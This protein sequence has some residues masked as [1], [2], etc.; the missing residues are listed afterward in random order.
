MGEWGGVRVRGTWA[1]MDGWGL[2]RHTVNSGQA[3]RTAVLLKADIILLRP[4]LFQIHFSRDSNYHT[5]NSCVSNL[6]RIYV[7]LCQG[8][9]PGPKRRRRRRK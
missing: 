6:P 9:P 2:V 8:Y 4:T 5:S 7:V 3:R 1:W